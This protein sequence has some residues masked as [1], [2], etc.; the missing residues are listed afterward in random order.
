MKK[1]T[2]VLVGGS[3]IIAAIVSLL[4]GAAPGSSGVEVTIGQLQAD[5]AKYKQSN[6]L[7]IQGDIIGDSVEWNADKIQLRF[8]VKDEEGN[9]LHVVHSGVKPDNFTEGIIAILEGTYREDGV[10]EAERVKTRC[11]SKYEARDPKDYDPEFH[12]QVQN[13]ASGGK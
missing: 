4:L 5:P 10:F 1:N 12:K 11:P 2:K 8:N 6:Y 3:L 9:I 13:Q 7:L